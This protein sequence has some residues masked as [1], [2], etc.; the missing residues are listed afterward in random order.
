MKREEEWRW[1]IPSGSISNKV[2][3]TVINSKRFDQYWCLVIKWD[4]VSLGKFCLVFNSCV[5]YISVSS[6]LIFFLSLSPHFVNIYNSLKRREWV[7]RVTRDEASCTGKKIN[8]FQ[9]KQVPLR[10]I[11]SE[12]VWDSIIKISNLTIFLWLG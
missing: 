9:L 7:A 10:W 8:L 12:I 2:N 3:M 1:V 4:W 11:I 5:Y 6:F